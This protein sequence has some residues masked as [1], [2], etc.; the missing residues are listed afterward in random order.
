MK[1]LIFG[2][3]ASVATITTSQ[4][5]MKKSPLNLSNLLKREKARMAPQTRMNKMVEIM[6][7]A[8]K[9]QMPSMEIML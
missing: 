6:V 5:S 4:R 7:K 9:A 2:Q 3:L 8:P 1:V